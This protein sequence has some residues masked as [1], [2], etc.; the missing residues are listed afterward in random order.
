MEKSTERKQFLFDV[1]VTALEGGIG[2]WSEAS[3]YHWSKSDTGTVDSDADLDGF[4]ADII[5]VE[6]EGKHYTITPA[7]IARGLGR[8]TDGKIDGIGGRWVADLM[9]AN[10]TNGE[11]GDFDAAGADAVVQAGLFGQVVY[12]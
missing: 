11:D 1:F 8:I 5:D 7:T 4:Y 6:D 2:Y 3:S 9:L 12:G 10:R